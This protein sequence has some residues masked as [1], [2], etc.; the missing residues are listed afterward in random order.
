MTVPDRRRIFVWALYD[1]AN[2]AYSAISITVLVFYIKGVVLPGKL[3]T[4]AWGWGIGTSM[5]TAAVLSPVLGALADLRASKHRWLTGTTLVGALGSCTLFWI[6]EDQP[7]LIVA[8]F[9]GISLCFELA[10]GFY[11]AFLPELADER[12][13]NRISAQGFALGYVGGGLAL[14][15]AVLILARGELVGLPPGDDLTG[16]LHTTHDAQFVVSVP[17]GLYELT[18]WL[19]DPA[20]RSR[21]VLAAEG[22]ELLRAN[23]D[24]AS[25]LQRRFP[26]EVRDDAMRLH[27]H[28]TDQHAPAAVAALV[29]RSL[30]TPQSWA[31][32][33]GPPGAAVADGFQPVL[34][35]DRLATSP[36]ADSPA[37]QP[38]DGA[39][40]WTGGEVTAVDRVI[41][42]R[43]RTGL[44]VMGLWWG[45]FSLPTLL[46]L[47]D[48]RA[49]VVQRA[50][51][52]RA[53]VGALRR[54]GHTLR[55]IR[56]Y[57]ML[58]LFLLAFLIFNEGVQTVISQ[59]S[60]FA[61][62]VLNISPTELILVVLMI[63]FAAFPGALLVGRLADRVGQ[64]P[65]LLGCLGIWVGL[66]VYAFFVTT[67]LEFWI[68]G[69]VVALVLGGTQSVSRA[70]MGRMTPLSH[71]AEFF[72][73]FNL[74]SKATSF[75]GPIVF[76]TTLAVTG[77]PHLSILSLIVFFLVGGG[78][79]WLVDIQRGQREAAAANQAA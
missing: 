18:V 24:A 33:F 7:W 39:F 46:L 45:L 12:S 4:L 19:G 31:F 62:E 1:W 66:L 38:S 3:G 30:Q 47:R 55:H 75:A 56:H 25:P 15:L 57:A 13:M 8:V 40:G 65:A 28:S 27:V 36:P 32:D 37:N 11:N 68:M 42:P 44:L 14:L 49:T 9:W 67:R 10:I 74:S 26:I 41:P 5:L 58:A 72:G 59:S 60:V 51:L 76:S 16:D 20:R 23:L 50:N 78:L 63:Q 22:H 29:L 79:V 69:A 17:A 70:I 35:T 2:S 64:K 21:V 43:L 34:P 48:Q 52:G 73:F 77:R 6:P 54:V 71:T 53:A 61:I